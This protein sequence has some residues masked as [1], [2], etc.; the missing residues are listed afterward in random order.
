MVWVKT[1]EENSS[2]E[3]EITVVGSKKKQTGLDRGV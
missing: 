3:V 1:S 2:I